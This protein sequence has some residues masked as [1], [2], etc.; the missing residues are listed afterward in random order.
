MPYQAWTGFVANQMAPVSFAIII[1]AFSFQDI[2]G[3][4]VLV[5]IEMTAIMYCSFAAFTEDLTSVFGQNFVIY[6][7]IT[8]IFT[9]FVI[10]NSRI[11]GE[12][13]TESERLM[14]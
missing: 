7:V 14:G 1:Q 9:T 6:F 3:N 8:I 10:F 2:P 5:Y 4:F 11:N 13:L 12:F